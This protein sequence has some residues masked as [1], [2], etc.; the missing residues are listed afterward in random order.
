M[1]KMVILVGMILSSCFL[2]ACQ[3]VSERVIETRAVEVEKILESNE[4]SDNININ[5]ENEDNQEPQE[6]IKSLEVDDIE[7][8][9]VRFQKG[10]IAVKKNLKEYFRDYPQKYIEAMANQE[11]Y[12]SI[13]EYTINEVFPLDIETTARYLDNLSAIEFHGQ[14]SKINQNIQDYI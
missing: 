2:V 14:E 8:A 11:D 4:T 9:M 5:R 1:K 10:S 13:F 12:E 7:K 3:P 6:K